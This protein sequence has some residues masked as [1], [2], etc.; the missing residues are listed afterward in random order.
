MNSP[1][2]ARQALGLN[3]TEMA[4]AMGVHRMLWRKWETGEQGITAAPQ[5]L[6]DTLIWFQS[7]SMLD[8]YLKHF[9]S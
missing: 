3:Q 5:R 6:L 8:A 4:N 2:E 9:D 1:K 7:I